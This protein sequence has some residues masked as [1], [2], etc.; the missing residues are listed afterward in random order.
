M[1]TVLEL[2]EKI[3]G[4]RERIRVEKENLEIF[5]PHIESLKNNK[6]GIAKQIEGLLS[7][8]SDLKES[9]RTIDENIWDAEQHLRKYKEQIIRWEQE[10]AEM[11]RQ[12]A[13]AEAEERAIYVLLEKTKEFDDVTKNA[14]WRQFIFPYQ[15]IGAKQMAAV[16]KGFL[17]DKRGL[18]KTIQS[19][20]YID[21]LQA[22]RVLYLVP[23]KFAANLRREVSRW[24][25][26]RPIFYLPEY[27]RTQWGFLL[28][29]IGHADNFV[30][31][32]NLEAWRRDEALVNSFKLTAFDTV[33]VDEAHYINN[34]STLSYKG[35][36]RIVEESYLCPSCK[37]PTTL[38]KAGNAL[39]IGCGL[40]GFF[41]PAEEEDQ[42]KSVKNVLLMTGSGIVNRPTDLWSLLHLLDPKGFPKL[43]SFQADFATQFS[44]NMWGWKRGA[45]ER[46]TQQ[47]GLR[48]LSRTR[49][50][51]GVE[52]PPQTVQE[53]EFEFNRHDYPQQYAIYKEVEK[54][55]ALMLESGDV[56]TIPEI[57]AR[58]TRLRQILTWPEG[59]EFKDPDTK[60]VVHRVGV[61]ESVKID[62]A[63]ELIEELIEG[64]ERVVLFSKFKAPLK[65]LNRRLEEKNISS[66]VYVGGTDDFLQDQILK[67]FDA[68]TASKT[69]PAWQVLLATFSMAGESVNFNAATSAI[70]LDREWNPAKEDQAMGRIQRIGQLKETT[71][72]ILHAINTIDEWMRTLIEQKAGVI[73]GFED[74]AALQRQLLSAMRETR[75]EDD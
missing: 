32:A 74:A 17:G 54:A 23:K 64:G 44:N 34:S 30:V 40:C 71:V 36:K 37:R 35:V 70:F 24:T 8:I 59:I 46:L 19:V 31:V 10:L 72:F 65:E 7:Q 1:S 9:I 20:A 12:L 56:M 48:Y 3:K 2:K 61:R 39:M 15:T 6:K 68:R 49:E 47:L 66:V 5:L 21:M 25:P 41:L 13:R 62:R 14:A 11:E 51:A 33:I 27:K 45:E 38:V 69:N 50:S 43:N 26:R 73:A 18:G 42:F 28:E 29:G 4:L 75:V 67:D 22:K 63:M 60:Q 58:I 55:F 16:G 53:V 57:V 52:V